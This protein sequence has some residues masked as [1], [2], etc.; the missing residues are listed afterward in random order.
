MKYYYAVSKD[1][2]FVILAA[3]AMQQLLPNFGASD[4]KRIAPYD[5]TMRG[6]PYWNCYHCDKPIVD[7]TGKP[8]NNPQDI[9]EFE[10]EYKSEEGKLYNQGLSQ[11]MI[12]EALEQLEG[13][14]TKSYEAITYYNNEMQKLILQLPDN[15]NTIWNIQNTISN[16]A[17]KLNEYYFHFFTPIYEPLVKNKAYYATDEEYRIVRDIYD[18]IMRQYGFYNKASVIKHISRIDLLEKGLDLVKSFKPDVEYY[19]D[20]TKLLLAAIAKSIG[21]PKKTYATY[22]ILA[23]ICDD[24]FEQYGYHCKDSDCD[25]KS[26][27]EDDFLEVANRR[28]NESDF[29]CKE[30]AFSCDNCKKNLLRGGDDEPQ[31]VSGHD[32]C[33]NC[34]YDLFKMCEDCGRTIYAEDANYDEHSGIILCNNCF[35][36][37]E[38][39]EDGIEGNLEDSDLQDAKQ[40]ESD[41]FYPLDEKTLEKSII[42]TIQLAASKNFKSPDQLKD[43]I[44]KRLQSKEAKSAILSELKDNTKTANILLRSFERQL[45]ELKRL[46]QEYP[47]L[48]GFKFLPVRLE[49]EGSKTHEGNVFVIYP[50]DALINYAESIQPGAA[51]SYKTFLELKGHHPGALGYARVSVSDGKIIVDNLQTDLDRQLFTDEQIKEHPA[52]GW[53]LTAIKKFWAPYLLDILRQY[54]KQIGKEIYLTSFDMQKKKWE[55][56]PERNKDVYD[57]L[58]EEM[59]FPKENVS[60]KPEDLKKQ[61]YSMHR[62][63]SYIDKAAFAFYDL[64]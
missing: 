13:F 43:F 53:W 32:Y 6:L 56:I 60:V 57:R 30:H 24:C 3:G 59:G 51:E 26:T 4:A 18:N 37:V 39:K 21:Q 33:N 25:F 35:D 55:K 64:R 47:K 5:G 48:T 61:E 1:M 22:I 52:L 8:I 36:M 19:Y 44:L 14:K 11:N 31:T 34:Y 27:D 16:L 29:Y 41:D 50:T 28:R 54:G 2:G 15:Q 42:P 45:S 40:I 7:D 12:N 38:G 10:K 9:V 17:A 23:P 58:P 46:K 49:I 20:N 63:A 62:I